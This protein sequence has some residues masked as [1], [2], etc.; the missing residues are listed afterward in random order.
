MIFYMFCSF[1]N[2]DDLLPNLFLISFHKIQKC[3]I[4]DKISKN[5]R[6]NVFG[7]G[8]LVNNKIWVL[9]LDLWMLGGWTTKTKVLSVMRIK[10]AKT[11]LNKIFWNFDISDKKSADFSCLFTFFQKNR[12]SIIFFTTF[13][14]LHN[15]QFWKATRFHFWI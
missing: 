15:C 11:L 10:N 9:L 4:L 8:I 1:S 5:C 2:F 12:K 6:W 3:H 14:E 13:W 7:K